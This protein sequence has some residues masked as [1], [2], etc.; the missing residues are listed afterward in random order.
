MI[1]QTLKLTTANHERFKPPAIRRRPTGHNGKNGNLVY[2]YV[3]YC[4]G[5]AK[6]GISEDPKARIRSMQSGCPFPIELLSIFP[7]SQKDAI[8]AEQA[9]LT[10]LNSAHWLSDWFKCTKNHALYA[11]TQA[12]SL[13]SVASV[14][15][16]KVRHFRR[17]RKISTPDGPFPS[18]TAAAKHYGVSKQAIHNRCKV[19]KNGWSFET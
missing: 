7:L 19:G 1:D 16:P 8:A 6:I 14:P 13:Y 11:A 9:S 3:A 2:L 18:S 17:A 15:P 4:K 12:S 5:Y 10:A